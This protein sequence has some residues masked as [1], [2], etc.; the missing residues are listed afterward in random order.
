MAAPLLIVGT[1]LAGYALLRAVRQLDR[2]RE[3]CMIDADAAAAYSKSQLPDG[4]AHGR[5]AGELVIATAEQ[6]AYRFEATIT[7]RRRALVLDPQRRILRTD[8]PAQAEQPWSQLVIATGAEAIRPAN[9]RGSGAAAIL[10][11]GSLAEYAYLRTQL[12]GRR[13]VAVIGGGI[14]GCE[15]AESFKRGGC[16][17]VLLEPG[18]RLLGRA[19]PAL[20]GQRVAE[21]LAAAGVRVRLEDGVQR[22]DHGLHDLELTTLG[23]HALPVDVVVAALGTRPRVQLARAAGLDVATGIVVDHGLR[24]SVEGIFALGACAEL[25]GRLFALGEDIE[26]GAHV[27]ADVLGGRATRMRWTP[28]VQHLNLACCPVALCEPPPV[29]GEWHESATARGVRALFHDRSGALRGFALVG[30][31]AGEASR[32]LG[33]V[34]R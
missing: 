20:C 8:N 24:T 7:P 4:L 32:L 23:G 13:R 12:S 33:R 1:G 18:N 9:V 30:E 26:N 5:D 11:V 16:E 22:I 21:A 14:S 19:C 10:T 17:V 29:A 2:H 27:L 6:M 25:G 31:P 28:R 15:L 34:V 3:I